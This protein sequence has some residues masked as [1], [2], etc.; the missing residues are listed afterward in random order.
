M[1]KVNADEIFLYHYEVLEPLERISADLIKKRMSLLLS[2]RLF[3]HNLSFLD[4]H[5]LRQ[6][7]MVLQAPHADVKVRGVKIPCSIA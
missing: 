7:A 1:L 4:G 3:W 6:S 5:Q 2:R